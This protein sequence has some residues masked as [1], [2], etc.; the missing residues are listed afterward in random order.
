MR[1]VR[2]VRACALAALVCAAGAAAA[3]QPGTI[4]GRVTDATTGRPV[5]SAQV[6]VVGSNTSA[7]TG[8]AGTYTLRNVPAGP[9]TV[10]VLVIGYAERSQPVT[11]QAGESATLNFQLQ[12]S[13]VGLA[14]VVVTATGEQ[15]RIEVGNAIS[16]IKAADVVERSAVSNVGD[17]LTARA[18]GVMVIPG[19]QTGAGVRV[20]IRG[21][22]SLSLTNNPIYIIDGIRV[23]GATGSLPNSGVASI[24]VG[25]TTPGRIGDLNP[26][27]IQS[28]E[29]VRGPSAATL[30]GT[31]AANGVIVI[32]TKRGVAGRPQWTYYTE[33]TAIRDRNDY[34]DAY[35]AWRTG[36]TAAT[37]SSRSNGVQC[38][39][40]AVAAG[41]CRQDSV[42]VFNPTKDSETTP[43]GTGRRQQHGLQLRGG[44]EAMRYFLHGEWENEDGV[45]TLPRFEERYLSARGLSL[46][47]DQLNPNRLGRVST[48]A[49]FNFNLPRNADISVNAGYTSQEL[50]LPRSDDSGTPGIAAN[51]YGGPG[52]KFNTNAA[53]DT[54]YGWR[55]FTPRTI[56][57]AVTEQEVQRVIGSVSGNWRPSGW[58]ALRGN[59][60]V[61]YTNRHDTQ[62]CR[63]GECPNSGEDRLGFTADQRT[64][65]FVYT[66]DGA[67]TATRSWSPRLETQT[68]AGVQF[69]RSVFDRTGALGRIIPP[70][71]T[72][73]STAARVL[74]DEAGSESRT[75]GGY[76]EQRLAFNDRLF[77]TGGLR[78]DRNSAFGADFG[79]V[80]Y[81]KLSASWVVSDEPFFPPMGFL[82][83]LR[84]R[85]AYGASGVQPG[86]TDAVLYYTGQ[87]VLGESGEAAG[88]VFTAL[89]NR[90]LR[91]E[92]ST[93]L[94]VGVD[95]RFWD[96][97]INTELTFYNKT[98]RDALV[99]RTLAP[100]LGTGLTERFE[101]LGEVRNRGVEALVSA[102]LVRGRRFGWDATFNAT[103]NAN[104]L[105]SLGGVPDIVLSSTL[106]HVQGYSLN[107][108]WS[109]PLLGYEDKDG[110][111][112]IEYSD[113]AALSEITVGD[114]EVFL[115]HSSP[116]REFSL[117]NGFDLGR[118]VRLSGMVDYKGGH[119]I[120]NNSERI[121]CASR[122]NCQGLVDPN[123]PL[124]EQARTVAVRQH[125]SRTVAGYIE[126]GDFIRFRELSLSFTAPERLSS[127]LLGSRDITLAL[128]ARNLGILW[129][130]YGGVDPEA[131][132]TTGDAPSSFQAF[133]PPTYF[134]LR[135]N[136]G[137]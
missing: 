69:Y 125:P 30:Y 99:E 35:Y 134:T 54:L 117:V 77:I 89:G 76:L 52:F 114:T 81:P 5:P 25:G 116:R 78:S 12:A 126:D 105:V 94:E 133:A 131:F 123:A 72:T 103:T 45:T 135:L 68:T 86:T 115:G 66:V 97:R 112:I 104:R 19:T 59:G 32:T 85:A 137:F 122:N 24:S 4:T 67:A 55:E 46:R 106:R 43:F 101:N 17:L 11:V 62:I 102:Q 118:S 119:K 90:N 98:S 73:I 23:E 21:T 40:S 100:S 22:S 129:T 127:R 75:L 18:P 44:S 1:F 87:A 28:I 84:L 57:Q 74:A 58:L 82:G 9:A 120:Y 47:D 31:D 41:T 38:F 37:T 49:N 29:V 2:F 8:E 96:D 53:G 65:L 88:V 113:N 132:G 93:E 109:R 128:A 34:P 107:G 61:D 79:T 64:N 42:T 56:Y 121:R 26:E 83:Q 15:R 136:L 91:P 39:L 111:G 110:D 3:Q 51:I 50:R 20:R 16:E 95:G 14:P 70:G 33:Q 48:R 124:F 10:R 6:R 60:G 13:A 108:W 7:L 80:F 92:R 63:T 27:E 36:T 130:K 71:A